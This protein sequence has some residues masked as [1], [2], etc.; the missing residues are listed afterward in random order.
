MVGKVIYDGYPPFFAPDLLPPL[1]SLTQGQAF[2]YIRGLHADF[3]A[4]RKHRQGIEGVM[5][6][7]EANAH[8]SHMAACPER[9]ETRAA[10]ANIHIT[11]L[12]VVGRIIAV[13]H[14]PCGRPFA[15]LAHYRPL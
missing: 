4:K 13:P 10:A 5:H 11:E 9:A 6:A 8:V 2:C 12:P 7:G 1:D 14:H 3:C 15:H